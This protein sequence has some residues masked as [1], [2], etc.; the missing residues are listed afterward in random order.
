MTY[1]EFYDFKLS[2]YLIATYL[3]KKQPELQQ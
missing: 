1:K 2:L 3:D